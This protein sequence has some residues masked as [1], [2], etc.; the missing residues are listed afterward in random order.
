[1]ERCLQRCVMKPLTAGVKLHPFVSC[2]LHNADVLPDSSNMR[3]AAF[4]RQKIW[5]HTQGLRNAEGC[6]CWDNMDP[7]AYLTSCSQGLPWPFRVGVLAGR[8]LDCRYLKL[9]LYVGFN[10][11]AGVG[12]TIGTEECVGQLL[13]AIILQLCI[14]ACAQGFKWQIYIPYLM[15]INHTWDEYA[16]LGWSEGGKDLVAGRPGSRW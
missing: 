9:L 3:D 8:Q 1:M 15:S 7:L 6:L 4:C 2:K 10:R 12:P 5:G 14:D 11:W 13:K 16:C